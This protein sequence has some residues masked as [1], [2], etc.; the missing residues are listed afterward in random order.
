MTLKAEEFDKLIVA[1]DR[2]GLLVAEAFMIVHHPQ[3]QRARA[4]L[5]SGAIGRLRHVDATFSYFNTDQTNIRNQSDT[6]GGGLPDIGVYTFGSVRFV[7]GQEPRRVPYAHIDFENGVD[8]FVHMAAEFPEF[9][10][11]AVV[12]MRAFP[13]Q[14]VV[15][16]GEEGVLRVS[17]PFNSNVHDQAEL[18][19]E[20]A[21]Q[22]VRTERFPGI[23]QYVLQVEAFCKSVSESSEYPCPLEFS[24]GTQSMI[25]MTYKAAG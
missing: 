19:L 6:G 25:D 11:S 15:F 7:T 21:G 8:T 23:N 4:L 13:R 17:C 16:H 24:K 9:T 10:Y 3:F 1:R 12:S 14:E 20:T 2:S 22:V 5:Q 18:H